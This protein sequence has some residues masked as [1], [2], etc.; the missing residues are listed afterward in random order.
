[1]KAVG[2]Q[3][4]EW[5]NKTTAPRGVWWANYREVCRLAQS[6]SAPAGRRA[7]PTIR[8]CLLPDVWQ[9][10]SEESPTRNSM[11]VWKSGPSQYGNNVE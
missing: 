9:I 8:L 3:E 11:N 2:V 5:Y 10:I 4:T 7:S 6:N 1:M